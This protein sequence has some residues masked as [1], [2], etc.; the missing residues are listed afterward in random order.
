MFLGFLSGSLS[1]DKSMQ[2]D[3]NK[4]KHKEKQSLIFDRWVSKLT[5][6]HLDCSFQYKQV[7][8]WCNDTQLSGGG[9]ISSS[10]SLMGVLNRADFLNGVFTVCIGVTPYDTKHLKSDFANISQFIRCSWS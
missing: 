4:Q 8:R 2:D 5:F 6:K 3:C 9:S 10:R 7:M 1:A